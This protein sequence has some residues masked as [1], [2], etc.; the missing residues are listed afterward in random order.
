MFWIA[1]ILGGAFF[2]VLFFG[3]KEKEQYSTNLLRKYARVQYS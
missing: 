1:E 2:L 3:N